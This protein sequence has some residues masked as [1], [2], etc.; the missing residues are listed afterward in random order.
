MKKMMNEDI[1][2]LCEEMPYLLVKDW[3]TGELED[4]EDYKYTWLT[5]NELPQGWQQHFLDMCEA[6]KEPLKKAGCLDKFCFVQ[7]KEKYNKMVCYYRNAN[8]EVEDII[9]KYENNAVNICTECGK[10]AT[11]YTMGYYLS[12]CD[13]CAKELKYTTYPLKEF[14]F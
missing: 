14:S 13:D 5:C 6:I 3:Y 1:K 4:H 10:P 9:N 8:Q 11:C 2:K 12:F 7:V